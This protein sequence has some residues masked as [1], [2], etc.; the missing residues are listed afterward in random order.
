MACGKSRFNNFRYQMEF[1]KLLYFYWS[2]EYTEY[3]NRILV[4]FLGSAVLDYKA[5]N[6]FRVF[7][8]DD[9]IW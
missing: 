6:S 5:V 9:A 7:R 4:C 1:E 3:Y 8:Y 2:L